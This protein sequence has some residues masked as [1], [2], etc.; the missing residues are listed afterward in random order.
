MLRKSLPAQQFLFPKKNLLTRSGHRILT[1]IKQL[2]MILLME[3]QQIHRIIPSIKQNILENK[4]DQGQYKI[5]FYLN[6]LK[7]I[8]LR[9]Q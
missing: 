6:Q 7:E 1:Q 3:I 8:F 4:E 9:Y 2:T 5:L